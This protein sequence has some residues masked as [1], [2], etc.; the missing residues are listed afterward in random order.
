MSAY[1]S[2]RNDAPAPRSYG[3]RVR[4]WFRP[5]RWVLLVTLVAVGAWLLKPVFFP[6]VPPIQAAVLVEEIR[7]A[8]KLATVELHATVVVSKDESTWYGAKFLF[9]VIPGKA[10]V[11]IDLANLQPSDIAVDGQKVSIT[12]PAPE[13]LYVDVDLE[14]REVFSAVGLLRPQFTPEESAALMESAQAKIR[15]K[16][17]Q[18]A[19]RERAAQQAQALVRRLVLA[20][21]AQEVAVT[22]RP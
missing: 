20:A 15:Q 10:A 2:R 8:A 14:R 4:R 16:A 6:P 19:V 9:M 1:P 17:E 13:V 5:L 12:L 21:G 18:E 7:D 3:E 11:G 22:V